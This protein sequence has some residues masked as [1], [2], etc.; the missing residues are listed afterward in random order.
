MFRY[1]IDSYLKE[2][3][4]AIHFPFFKEASNQPRD[5]VRMHDQVP[6]ASFSSG[7]GELQGPETSYLIECVGSVL[8]Q[9]IAEVLIKR[10]VDP[11][12]YLGRCLKNY[13]RIRDVEIKESM[14]NNEIINLSQLEENETSLETKNEEKTSDITTESKNNEHYSDDK[15]INNDIDMNNINEIEANNNNNDDIEIQD[16][17]Q[18][19]SD[20]ENDV[21]ES[22]NQGE[23]DDDDDADDGEQSTLKFDNETDDEITF[24][25]QIKQD[26]N[27]TPL[28]DITDPDHH[29]DENDDDQ[30][31]EVTDSEVQ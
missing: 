4:Q 29:D 25:S 8:R 21:K 24:E 27:E 5:L 3:K 18:L 11:I 20:S 26:I 1:S 23:V 15:M 16:R 31:E 13:I 14:E 10:P 28:E 22:I 7:S 6:S 2:W 30:T 19:Q 12:D 17:N 9:Y